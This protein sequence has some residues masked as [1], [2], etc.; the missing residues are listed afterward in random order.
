VSSRV[1][2]FS[3]EDRQIEEMKTKARE[4][5]SNKF[6]SINTVSITIGRQ[7]NKQKEEERKLV[8]KLVGRKSLLCR[9]KR[10]TVMEVPLA[11]IELAQ[12][13]K[14]RQIVGRTRKRGWAS[15]KREIHLGKE[16][17]GGIDR[18]SGET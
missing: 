12:S 17:G 18:V 1:V 16:A 5:I 14:R 11:E 8:E 2:N 4:N 7:G 9:R 15:E 3:S 6:E 10:R 13:I